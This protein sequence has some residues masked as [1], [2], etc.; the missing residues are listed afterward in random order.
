MS[1]LGASTWTPGT[2]CARVCRLL[3]R[4]AAGMEHDWSRPSSSRRNDLVL[5]EP[6]PGVLGT[7]HPFFRL[8]GVDAL[9]MISFFVSFPS[10][11]DVRRPGFCAANGSDRCPI[12]CSRPSLDGL[13]LLTLD[14]Q[15]RVEKEIRACKIRSTKC[16]NKPRWFQIPTMIS[17]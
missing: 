2:A 3:R 10:A 6:I 9:V 14:I 1:A 4:G 12:Y 13:P 16:S 7:I 8:V 17:R 5:E 15:A 11:I